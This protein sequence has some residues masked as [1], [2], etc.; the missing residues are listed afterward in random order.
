MDL[1]NDI[2]YDKSWDPS[3]TYSILRSRFS[4]SNARYHKDTPYGKA[5]PLFV[6][7]PFYQA[8]VDGYLDDIIAAIL[9]KDNWVERGQNAAPLAAHTVFRSVKEGEEL[10]RDDAS[11][12]TKLDGEGRPDERKPILEWD[13]DNQL[14]RIYLPVDKATQ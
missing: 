4:I 11:S 12:T 13:I 7:V 3:T 5:R 2:L 10:P 6:N 1:T 14:F 8:I 9:D